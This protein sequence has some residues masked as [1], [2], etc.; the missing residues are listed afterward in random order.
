M[1]YKNIR[2]F[3]FDMD[4]TIYLGNN[5]FPFVPELL[6]LIREQGKHYLFMT[7]NSSKNINGYVEKLKKLGIDA[8]REDFV[9]STTVTVNYIKKHLDGKKLYVFGTQALKD[10]FIAEG[11][12]VH[13]DYSDDIEGIVMGF[14]TELT[15]KK[16]DDVSKL[17][18]E[19]DIPYIATNPDYVCPTEYGYVPDCGSIADALYNATG[20]RPLFIGKPEPAMPLYAVEKMS[21]KDPLVTRENTLV[22]GD[23][24]YTDIAC[25]I[26]A[27]IK[28]MLVLSGET[29]QKMADESEF[30]PTVTV[31]DCSILLDEL[32]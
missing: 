2:L 32:K 3:L 24:L 7:N 12:D 28:S 4:G 13:E 17:L 14:D 15:F 11:I 9:N 25:G 31:K 22:I 26:N 16:L 27:G 18:T 20:K 19:K 5:L 1:D 29:T 30:K 6:R 21:E 8:T 10:A 23:R